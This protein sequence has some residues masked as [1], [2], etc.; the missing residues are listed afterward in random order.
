MPTHQTGLVHALREHVQLGVGRS[1]F[2]FTHQIRAKVIEME[3]EGVDLRLLNEVLAF[4]I[5]YQ[6]QK[7][8]EALSHLFELM[9]L[10]ERSGLQHLS[11][12]LPLR[13]AKGDLFFTVKAVQE[14]QSGF[15]LSSK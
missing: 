2:I 4:V 1:R 15:R 9:E 11:F 12:A 7:V 14:R 8:V 10:V 3:L 5:L 6:E 13:F